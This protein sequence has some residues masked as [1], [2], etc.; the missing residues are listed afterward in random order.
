[1]AGGLE[2]RGTLAPS[3]ARQA[4]QAREEVGLGN[5]TAER[6]GSM[7]ATNF[8]RSM[9]MG[10]NMGGEKEDAHGEESAPADL[11][12]GMVAMAGL[13]LEETTAEDVIANVEKMLNNDKAK[14][15]AMLKDKK[16]D[17]TALDLN[18]AVV[19]KDKK[20]KEMAKPA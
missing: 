3:A 15:G 16:S 10:V 13:D 17:N 19:A 4:K 7:A 2:R 5:A 9:T 18:T 11:N 14:T 1:L 8:G 20:K 6:R 12:A